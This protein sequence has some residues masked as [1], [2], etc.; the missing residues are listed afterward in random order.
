[1]RSIHKKV[2]LPLRYRTEGDTRWRTGQTE[3]ISRTGLLFR[4]DAPPTPGAVVEVVLVSTATLTGGPPSELL[5]A[6]KVTRVINSP[7]ERRTL[8]AVEWHSIIG[9]ALDVFLGNL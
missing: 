2:R 8:I 1:M 6:G 5:C 4:A 7:V 3:N 9:D